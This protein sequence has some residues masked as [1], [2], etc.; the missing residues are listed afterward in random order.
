LAV[1]EPGD[2]PAPFV[3]DRSYDNN[4][5]VRP[6]FAGY[7]AVRAE[8]DALG[9]YPYDDDFLGKIPG[10]EG[11]NEATGIYMLQTMH[12]LD[13]VAVKVSDFKEAG[14]VDGDSIED[15]RVYRGTV[16]VYGFYSG[17]T[18]YHEYPGARLAK[19]GRGRLVMTEKKK[20]NGVHL[21][22]TVMIL[23]EEPKKGARS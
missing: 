11:P 2:S 19:D 17:G 18:G 10:L 15:G 22:G 12:R 9:K 7:L 14:G 21:H 4:E 20:R 1:A 6:Y 16:A 13:E 3:W 8:M 5:Q 23:A